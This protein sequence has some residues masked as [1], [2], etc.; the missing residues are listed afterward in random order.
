[1]FNPPAPRWNPYPDSGQ[2][3]G[4]ATYLAFSYG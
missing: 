1:V 3:V 2:D 4:T